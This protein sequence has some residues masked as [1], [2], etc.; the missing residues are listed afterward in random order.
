MSK[1]N[2]EFG[3]SREL[4]LKSNEEL[5]RLLKE[6]NA[7]KVDKDDLRYDIFK[8]IYEMIADNIALRLKINGYAEGILEQTNQKLDRYVNMFAK[9]EIENIQDK[10]KKLT[11]TKGQGGKDSRDNE[12]TAK[13]DGEFEKRKQL[14]TL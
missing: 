3:G 9:R 11:I 7:Q 8:M 4:L 13:G 10:G 12:E 5:K 1:D 14:R 2:L 6:L